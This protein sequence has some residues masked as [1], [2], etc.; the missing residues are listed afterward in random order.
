MAIFAFAFSPPISVSSSSQRLLMDECTSNYVFIPSSTFTPQ[1][2]SI[3]Y[4]ISPLLSSS[5]QSDKERSSSTNDMQTLGNKIILQ[6]ALQCGATEPMLDIAWKADRI[7]V[8]VDVTADEDYVD[9][10][11]GELDDDDAFLDSLELN[12]ELDDM[13]E[14]ED[15]NIMYEEGVGYDV[16]DID[17]DEEEFLQTIESTSTSSD[18]PIDLTLQIAR[19]INELLAADG[20]DSPAFKIAKL[21]EIE[22]STPPFDNVLRGRLMFEN[23][24]GF[25]VM[26]EHFEEPKKKKKK[27]K[28]KAFKDSTPTNDASDSSIEQEEVAKPKLT[29]TEGKLVERDYEKE[30]TLINVKGRIKKI[31]NDKIESVCL[32]K[33]KREKGAK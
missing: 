33:A 12:G 21:H 22:V 26:I 8:T 9:I 27:K 28:S 13:I 6:A 4:R 11:D 19:T 2:N 23:Y 29:I 31:K 20:E 16:Q 18:S 30:V 17:E 7:V 5:I 3:S 24:K 14:Y 10:D 25:D 15:D 1:Y 32:P